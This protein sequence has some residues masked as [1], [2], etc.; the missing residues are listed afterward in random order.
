MESAKECIEVLLD[1]FRRIV[2]EVATI[3]SAYIYAYATSEL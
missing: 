2:V 1:R 3:G